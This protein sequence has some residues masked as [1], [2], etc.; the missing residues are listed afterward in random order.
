MTQHWRPSSRSRASFASTDMNNQIDATGSSPQPIAKFIGEFTH[1]QLTEKCCSRNW[2]TSIN[3][4]RSTGIDSIRYR[5]RHRAAIFPHT[6]SRYKATLHRQSW[7]QG[8]ERVNCK[9]DRSIKGEH[10]EIVLRELSH[11]IDKAHIWINILLLV[12]DHKSPYWSALY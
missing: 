9:R 6:P 11:R 12:N 1:L 4:S 5:L 3:Q 8:R 7:H 10:R 2:R